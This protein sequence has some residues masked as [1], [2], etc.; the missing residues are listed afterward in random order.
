[1]E[2]WLIR[3]TKNHL[4][5]YR[6]ALGVDELVCR[7]LAN[8]GIADYEAAV[9]FLQPDFEQMHDP[10]LMKDLEKGADILSG[11]I[12]AGKKI[13]IIGDYDVDGV[14]STC[15]LYKALLRCGAQVD[16]DIP[17]RILDGYGIN[18]EMIAKARKE[19]VDTLLT[20][21]NGIAAA[22]QIACA[23]SLGLTVIITD[24]HEVPFTEDDA[25]RKTYLTPGA[26]AVIDI[27]QADC[28]YPFKLL[29][30]AGVAY[31][32][33][34]VLY[35]KMEISQEELFP[36][37][38]FAAIATVC[39]VVD[40]IGE[41]R[42]FVKKGLEML[43]NTQNAGLK[44]LIRQTGIEGVNLDAY[45][46]GFILGPCL[47]ASG[48]L[49][50]AVKGLQL[51]LSE[52]GTEAE[53]LAAE[54][55]RL[56]VRRREM[57]LKGVEETVRVIESS[58]LKK[59]KVCLVYKPDVHE[60]IA[61]IIAGKIRERYNVPTI[62]LTDSEQGVKGSGRSIEEYNMFEELAKCSALLTRFGGHAMAAGLS[63]NPDKVDE[64]RDV[65]NRSA[66]L[67]EEDLK[68]KIRVDG[69]LDLDKIDLAL[70]E[71]LKIFEPYGKGNWKPLFAETDVDAVRGAV[72]GAKRNVLKLKLRT[73]GNKYLDCVYFGDIEE[74]E[75]RTAGKFGTEELDKLYA[76]QN[77][78]V[79]LDMIFT[80]EVNEYNGHKSAQ[81]VL[82]HYR[83]GEEV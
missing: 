10:K 15:L 25:G 57:T 23:K 21:D 67:T 30:G 50:T 81:L 36:L 7:V 12:A 61:G 66:K 49:D 11:K 6:E 16:F 4:N 19:G 38:E 34:Q 39:D 24:H 56:N 78:K 79:R 8:R 42:I 9:S 31:K 68:R 70:A 17:H 58:D 77:N 18:E 5:E 20:C 65:L 44:A 41:N 69:L 35:E 55:H 48:R 45:S 46:L 52:D 27:K 33:V 59:D 76:G 28:A 2:K 40:L 73:P 83:F 13:R 64:L 63:L 60:S 72:L 51:L 3:N 29:C 53:E 75:S 37:A 1:M 22:E 82:R 71:M 54:L 62:V 14:A 74:F 26:D 43:N 80:L 47:N 32:L